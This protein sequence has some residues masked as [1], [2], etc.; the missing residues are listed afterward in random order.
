MNITKTIFTLECYQNGEARDFMRGWKVHA[1][2]GHHF[3]HEFDTLDDAE[4]A[5]RELKRNHFLRDGGEY[6]RIVAEA[7]EDEA[8]IAEAEKRADAALEEFVRNGSIDDDSNYYGIRS[9]EVFDISS[10]AAA[11]IL[12]NEEDA[13]YREL[14]NALDRFGIDIEPVDASDMAERG[15]DDPKAAAADENSDRLGDRIENARRFIEVC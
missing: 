4:E 7:G 11:I 13:D 12:A 10:N 3:N 14:I 9:W 6:D 1:A 2:P 5:L 8:A 15:E